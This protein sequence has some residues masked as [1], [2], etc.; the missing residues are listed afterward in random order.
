[1]WNHFCHPAAGWQ[2]PS[3]YP[4]L[5]LPHPVLASLHP[6]HGSERTSA[7]LSKAKE[8][9]PLCTQSVISVNYA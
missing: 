6:D 5:W 2:G 4:N 3:L 7:C 8:T 1:M 9:S